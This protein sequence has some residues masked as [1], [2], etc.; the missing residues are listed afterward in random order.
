MMSPTLGGTM[1]NH[2]RGCMM[3]SPTRGRVKGSAQGEVENHAHGEGRGVPPHGTASMDVQKPEEVMDQR[4]AKAQEEP[5]NL[6]DMGDDQL[7]LDSDIMKGGLVPTDNQLPPQQ[8]EEIEE[9]ED[10]VAYS[11]N[12][13][14]EDEDGTLREGDQEKKRKRDE[15]YNRKHPTD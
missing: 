2:T 5:H 11:S 9:V 1:M 3:M 13:G 14:D 7:N 15:K 6:M 8:E 4:P 10:Q 12:E